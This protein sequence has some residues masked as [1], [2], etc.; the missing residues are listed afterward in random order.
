MEVTFTRQRVLEVARSWIGTPYRHQGRTKGP[1]GGVDCVGLIIGMHHDLY[2][3][4]AG[5]FPPYTADWA[6]K[7]RKELLVTLMRDHANSVE[8]PLKQPFTID[9]VR[10]GDIFV[11]RMKHSG[12]AKHCGIFS[13]DGKIIHAYS[14]HAVAEDWIPPGWGLRICYVFQFKGVID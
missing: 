10:P 8:V 2:G 3:Y 9:Q 11:M 4:D 5:D 7:A 14:G 6:E 13:E 12:P 1:D